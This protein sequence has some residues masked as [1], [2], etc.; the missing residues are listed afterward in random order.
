[1]IRL[2]DNA[3]AYMAMLGYKDIVLLTDDARTWCD[4]S[5]AEVSVSFTGGDGSEYAEGY[6]REETQI[7]AVYVPLH[8]VLLEENAAIRYEKYPWIEKFELDGIKPAAVCCILQPPAW[9]YTIIHFS[10]QF[11]HIIDKRSL[12]LIKYTKWKPVIHVAG[13]SLLNY[14]QWLKGKSTKGDSYEWFCR[15]HEQHSV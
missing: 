12:F 15:F 13:Y 5:K 6:F 9:L 2:N 10:S 4:P 1:M 11:V 8:G 14:C 7:G 3:I